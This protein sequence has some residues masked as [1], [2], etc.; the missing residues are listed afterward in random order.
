MK[1]E[2]LKVDD[3]FYLVDPVTGRDSVDK[4]TK[5]DEAFAI[6]DARC[7]GD[8]PTLFLIEPQMVVRKV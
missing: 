6:R 8:K 2:D 4:Y 5:T 1:F 3:K 7:K